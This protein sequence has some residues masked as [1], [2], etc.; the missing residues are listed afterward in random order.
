MCFIDFLNASLYNKLKSISNFLTFPRWRVVNVLISTKIGFLYSRRQIPDFFFVL[1]VEVA[2]LEIVFVDFVGRSKTLRFIAFGGFFFFLESSR[3]CGRRSCRHCRRGFLRICFFGDARSL[4]FVRYNYFDGFV[5]ILHFEFRFGW[6]VTNLALAFDAFRFRVP[7]WR[8]F[9]FAFR[10]FRQTSDCN[11]FFYRPFLDVD[12]SFSLGYF[13]FNAVKKI[14]NNIRRI[15]WSGR[16]LLNG[17]WRFYSRFK[18]III[19]S[20]S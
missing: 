19:V 5:R 15:D 14:F 9:A 2:S 11:R 13:T 10:E 7:R 1:F 6:N 20:D 3:S 8:S 4:R 16:I 12:D 17:H 18:T